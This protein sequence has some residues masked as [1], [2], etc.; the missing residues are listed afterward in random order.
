[1]DFLIR[2]E[3]E[4]LK[5]DIASKDAAVEADKYAFEVKL[6]NGLGDDII[7]TLNN[8]PKKSLWLKWKYKLAKW[9]QEWRDKRILK[10]GGF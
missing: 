8:P 2:K 9:K 6:L 7:K 10:K 3:I 5:R 1:M 4:G